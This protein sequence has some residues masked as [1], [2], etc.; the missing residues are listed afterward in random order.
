MTQQN[1]HL[2]FSAD[3]NKLWAIMTIQYPRKH[4]ANLQVFVYVLRHNDFLIY[5]SELTF[6]N[7]KVFLVSIIVLKLFETK[8]L[9]RGKKRCVFWTFRKQNRI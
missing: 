3:L 5:V 1:K 6:E 2:A 9:T 8:E 4:Q 7:S